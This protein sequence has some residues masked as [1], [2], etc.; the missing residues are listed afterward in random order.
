MMNSTWC[1]NSVA[2]T[3]SCEAVSAVFPAWETAFA[4]VAMHH[5]DAIADPEL[6][7][8]M[9]SFVAEEMSHAAAHSAFNRRNGLKEMEDAEHEKTALVHKRPG[10][11]LWLGTMI[12][13]EHFASCMARMYLANCQGDDRD[14]KLFAWHSREELGHKALAFDVWR[15]LGY[16]DKLLMR[17]VRQN[18]AY[19]L[20]AVFRHVTARVK[21]AG[22]FQDWVGYVVWLGK[23]VRWVG[24][25]MLRIYLP[26]FH[27]DHA[28]D[29][30]FMETYA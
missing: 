4:A 19:I 14:H 16:S 20:K 30:R 22:R 23:V 9:R 11:K 18:Q 27:P 13:I 8:R 24:L 26:N 29:R 5:L 15:A 25:P 3:A 17:I 2:W 28:D 12:S 10:R 6:R 1:N 21:E 7:E